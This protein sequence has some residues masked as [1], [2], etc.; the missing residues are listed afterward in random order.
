LTHVWQQPSLCCATAPAVVRGLVYV[1]ASDA[2]NAYDARSGQLRWSTRLG[3]SIVA[4]PTVANGKVFVTAHEVFALDAA[5]G[6]LL[7]SRHLN[8]HDTLTS[9]IVWKGMVFVAADDSLWAYDESTGDTIWRLFS[10]LLSDP[11]LEN[12]TLYV[13]ET[14]GQS[15]WVDAV[16]AFTGIVRWQSKDLG[17]Q[18]APPVVTKR[19]VFAL[20]E[21]TA[22]ALSR[23]DGQLLWSRPVSAPGRLGLAHGLLFV[24]AAYSLNALHLADGSLEWS[25]PGDLGTWAATPALEHDVVYARTSNDG[26]SAYEARS[27]TLLWTSHLG[28][29]PIFSAPVIVDGFL[30]F[31]AV[32]G[33]LHAYAL[34]DPSS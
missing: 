25:A 21:G 24:T 29:D 16:D 28:A 15:G 3:N 26:M 23:L 2:V 30:Y 12:G 33:M 1:G 31:A 13:Q 10:G 34:P 14:S 11:V 8:G 6:S 20:G 5:S 18:H 4:R 32:D 22:V 17:I 19:A 27:G 9:P 7:W